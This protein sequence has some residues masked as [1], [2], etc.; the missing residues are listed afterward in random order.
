MQ[1]HSSNHEITG[2]FFVGVGCKT[3]VQGEAVGGALDFSP[4]L[5]HRRFG[6]VQLLS[7]GL[8]ANTVSQTHRE[9][10]S[11]IYRRTDPGL[12]LGQHCHLCHT[13]GRRSAFPVSV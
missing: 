10:Q 1:D 5:Y 13:W 11:G 9:V 6:G 3:D 12:I 8:Q 2:G 4:W 7:I